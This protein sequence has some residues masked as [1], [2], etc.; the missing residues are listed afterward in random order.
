MY[1]PILN[2]LQFKERLHA[3]WFENTTSRNVLTS[4]VVECSEDYDFILSELRE[5]RGIPINC[6]LADVC[7]FKWNES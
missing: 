1:G 4:F 6:M 7:S 5:K 2:E 3:Q